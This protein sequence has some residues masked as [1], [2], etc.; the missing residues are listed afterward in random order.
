M[1][2]IHGQLVHYVIPQDADVEGACRPAVVVR[3]WT[4][5]RVNL[6]VFLDGT[7]DGDDGVGMRWA[8]SIHRQDHSLQPGHWHLADTCPHRK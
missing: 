5:D 8:T 7:S 2:Q 1:S 4:P 6:Q 3:E